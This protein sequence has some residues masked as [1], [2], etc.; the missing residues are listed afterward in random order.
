MPAPTPTSW[1]LTVAI[2]WIDL[3]LLLTP[4][5]RRTTWRDQWRADLWHYW[6]W[7]SREPMPVS[8]RTWRLVR[9]AAPAPLHALSLRLAEW[10]LQMLFHDLRLA[11]RLLVRRPAFRLAVKGMTMQLATEEPWRTLPFVDV[12]AAPPIVIAEDDDEEEEDDDEDDDD[13]LDDDDD[14]GPEV[15]Q[16]IE[17]VEDFDDDDFDD[18]FDV[19]F[20]EEFDDEDDAHGDD[21]HIPTRDEGPDDF[22]DD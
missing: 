19:D 4:A 12:V 6:L 18:E 11:W 1:P 7:L 21:S 13:E 3:W 5:S 2:F 22:D 15:E 16:P 17:P 10:S 14:I 9:R 8:S 20:E